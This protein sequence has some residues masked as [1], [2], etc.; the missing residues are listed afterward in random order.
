MNLLGIS[1]ISE[2]VARAHDLGVMWAWCATSPATFAS[3]IRSPYHTQQ[4][5][6]GM[7]AH[8]FP[9]CEPS[10]KFI[11]TVCVDR[12][13]ITL[14]KF[15]HRVPL[16]LVTWH[17]QLLYRLFGS[18]SVAVHVTDFDSVVL[19]S[20]LVSWEGTRVQVAALTSL[21][22][23]NACVSAHIRGTGRAFTAL[24]GLQEFVLLPP[25][26][27]GSLV[28]AEHTPRLRRFTA[29]GCRVEYL[30]PLSELRHLQEVQLA[31]TLI[32]DT[33]LRILAQLPLLTTLDVSSCPHLSTLE[34]LACSATL[35][36]LR[37]ASCERLM[38]VA[39]L[40]TLATLR[41][42]DLSENMFL[43]TEFAFF[44]AQ[45]SLRL[46]TGEFAHLRWPRDDP[47]RT[48][49]LGSVTHLNLS[50]GTLPNISWLCGAHSLETLYLNHTNVT[51]ACMA[52]LVPHIP[53][54]RVLSLAYC[55]R[56]HTNLDFIQSLCSLTTLTITR[57]SLPFP[58]PQMA[59]LQRT[60]TITLL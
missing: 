57:N 52:V 6:A 35:R 13:G 14:N 60:R 28:V 10:G 7:S 39:R 31:Q 42:V 2:Y 12:M 18:T 58:F 50:Y 46:E 27:P 41:I 53:L 51:A 11:C 34:P 40:G 37:A 9:L 23:V 48:R 33:E 22:R 3:M 19:G 24:A 44:I 29:S 4:V 30:K 45:P 56:L 59:E 8:Y 55:E 43:P 26:E 38:R 54:L 5:S 32:R 20:L 25:C 21:H 47:P 49:L 15:L 17:T 1:T 16:W 36:V